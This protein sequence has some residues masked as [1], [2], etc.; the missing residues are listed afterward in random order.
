MTYDKPVHLDWGGG[1]VPGRVGRRGRC[2]MFAPEKRLT[3]S[4]RDV[5]C[6]KCK[7]TQ[8]YRGLRREAR[9]RQAIA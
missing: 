8:Y 6:R 5:T 1:T 3:A 7:D 9:E 4:W 2:G